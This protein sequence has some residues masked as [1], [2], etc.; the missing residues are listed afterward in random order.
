[1]GKGIES[2]IAMGSALAMILSYLTNKSILYAVLHGIC[3]W[4]YVI[5]FAITH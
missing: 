4:I 2:G 5:Y 3:N 1:M